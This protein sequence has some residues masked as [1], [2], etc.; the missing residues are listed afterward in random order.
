MVHDKQTG[1]RAHAEDN[2]PLFPL[3]RIGIRYE[4]GKVIGKN[5]LPKS[6]NPKMRIG[7]SFLQLAS[8]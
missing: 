5:G 2:K 3:R 8:L 1:L 6:C 7:N 4:T